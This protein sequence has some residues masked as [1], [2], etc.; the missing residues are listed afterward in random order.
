MR[1]NL[2]NRVTAMYDRQVLAKMMLDIQNQVNALSE[3]Q[4]VGRYNAATSAPT[5]GSYAIGDIVYNSNPSELGSASSKYILLAWICTDDDPLTFK[6][7]R[8]LTGN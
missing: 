2:F 5:T 1:L 8:C 6:E 3:G 7:L 4:L